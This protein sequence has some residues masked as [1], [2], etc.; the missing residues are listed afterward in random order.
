MR[1]VSRR[2]VGFAVMM[3]LLGLVAFSDPVSAGQADANNDWMA[4]FSS[5]DEIPLTDN[6]T[7]GIAWMH[8]NDDGQSMN[9]V[10]WV[11]AIN[12]PIAAHI[13]MG[14][15]GV[16]GPVVVA[17]YAGKNVGSFSGVMSSGTITAK[18]LDGPLKGK[19][20]DDLFTAMKTN[21]AYVNVHTEAHPGGEARGMI[22]SDEDG[23]LGG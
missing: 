22:R 17:L 18:D 21:G 6:G 5:S 10:L 14:G 4:T 20:M 9:W 23:R 1:T 11:S 12:N 19:T 13:H 2:F 8:I 16:N 7:W 3:T 15:P